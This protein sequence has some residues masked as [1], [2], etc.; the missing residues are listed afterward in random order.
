MATH[1]NHTIEIH[2]TYRVIVDG[3]RINLSLMVDDN[4]EVHCHALPNYQLS[5]ALDLVKVMVDLFPD[6]F[7]NSH[8]QSSGSGHG[9]GRGSGGHSSRRATARRRASR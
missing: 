6:S 4:G 7:G 9:R 3:K 5:S 2:T 8:K 1:K